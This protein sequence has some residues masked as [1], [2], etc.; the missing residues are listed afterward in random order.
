VVSGYVPADSATPTVTHSLGTTDLMI[1][2][3]D[4][5]T[6]GWPVFSAAST[7]VNAVQFTFTSAPTANR[8]RYTILAGTPSL[9]SPQVR[10]VPVAQAYASSLTI[11]AAGGNNRVVTATGNLTLNEPSNGADGQMLLVRV[12]A[13]G[14]QRVVTFSGLLKR[15]SSIGTTVTI[16]NGL[17]GDIGL[18]YEAAYG[19]TVRAAQVA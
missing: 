8:Y 10:D 9:S 16:A 15:P 12:I 4:E 2:V 18:Y 19:W 11:N 3:H 5:I 17:R 14:G 6:G 7:S 1:A 13:Q